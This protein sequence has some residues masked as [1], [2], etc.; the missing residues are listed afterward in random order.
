MTKIYIS[1]PISGYSLIEVKER[2]KKVKKRLS[3]EG[4]EVITP[5]DVCD[6]E[7]KPYEYYMGR[8]VEAL[9]KCDVVYFCEGWQNSK[10]CMSEFEMARIYG[11]VLKFE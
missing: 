6:E 8:D 2:A 7:G 4:V 10:G 5:F 9:L 1:I 3:A 11:K